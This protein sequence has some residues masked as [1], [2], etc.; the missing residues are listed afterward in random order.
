MFLNPQPTFKELEKYYSGDYCPHT[1]IEKEGGLPIKIRRYLYNICVKHN[2]IFKFFLYPLFPF[3]RGIKI[4]PNGKYLDVGCGGGQFLYEIKRFNPAAEYHGIEVG[5]IDEKEIKKYNLKVFKGV[6]EESRYPD[7]YFDVITMNSVFAHV[8][9]PSETMKELKRILNPG[10]TLIIAGLN[11]RSLAYKLFG[12]YWYHL[13]AP[14]HLFVYSDEILKKYAEKFNFKI[15]KIK[16]GSAD[17][18]DSASFIASGRHYFNNS[19]TYEKIRK[20]I[21]KR[22]KNRFIQLIFIFLALL[23]IPLS[24]LLNILKFGDT[25]EIWLKK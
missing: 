6:L 23:L 21:S 14:R 12:K 13:D 18:I 22:R 7:D 10:G 20:L 1:R 16:C 17:Q 8:Y 4:V 3:I 24:I 2:F 25:I 5:N 11:Y 9:N 15:E 19:R